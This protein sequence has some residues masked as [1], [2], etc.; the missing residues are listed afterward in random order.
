MGDALD[1]MAPKGQ[2]MFDRVVVAVLFGGDGAWQRRKTTR[3][4][5]KADG[6][7]EQEKERMNFLSATRQRP[8]ASFLT[9]LKSL[10]S[11]V[12]M[13]RKS[14][15]CFLRLSLATDPED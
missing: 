9:S 1:P 2:L 5:H 12:W 13:Q 15:I 7:R 8:D 4:G 14:P 10:L 11:F 3:E 6:A